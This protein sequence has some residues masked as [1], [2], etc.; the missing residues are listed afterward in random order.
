[1]ALFKGVPVC[2]KKL[3]KGN[4]KYES[5]LGKKG[6]ACVTLLTLILT[7]R[8]LHHYAQ[9]MKELPRKLTR[10]HDVV[11]AGFENPFALC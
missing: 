1:M 7:Y 10:T 11:G 3:R 8:G 5:V 4:C 9:V 6:V 2:P